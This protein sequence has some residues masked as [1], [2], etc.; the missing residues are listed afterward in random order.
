MRHRQ[1]HGWTLIELVATMT[2]AT[3]MFGILFALIHGF[4]RLERRS[5][6]ELHTRSSLE[7][8]ATQFRDDAH[9]ARALAPAPAADGPSPA[10]WDLHLDGGRR[11]EYRVVDEGLDRI[12]R[13]GDRIERRERYRL[14]EAMAAS[15]DLPSEKTGSMAVLRIAPD[16]SAPPEPDNHPVRIEAALGFDRRFET[17]G[18]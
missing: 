11:V 17:R 10:G 2:V 4:F 12:E 16:G 3:T 13:V 18:R 1:R 15:V 6:E 9:A 14:P 5:R 7:R 8:L